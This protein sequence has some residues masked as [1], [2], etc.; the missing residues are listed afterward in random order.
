MCL[1]GKDMCTTIEAV[2]RRM[3]HDSNHVSIIHANH[4]DINFVIGTIFRPLCEAC[5]TDPTLRRA[6]GILHDWITELDVDEDVV[7][8]F[9]DLRSC[10][11]LLCASSHDSRIRVLLDTYFD[12][13]SSQCSYIQG[14]ASISTTVSRAYVF[15]TVARRFLAELTTTQR[16]RSIDHAIVADA[17]T[18]SVYGHTTPRTPVNL[19]RGVAYNV[20]DKVVCSVSV[21]AS[22]DIPVVST[23]QETDAIRRFGDKTL[24]ALTG[25]LGRHLICAGGAPCAAVCG[26]D[27]TDADLFMVGVDSIELGYDILRTAIRDLSRNLMNGSSIS[28][29]CRRIPAL[30]Y[31]YRNVLTV[32]IAT[33]SRLEPYTVTS[34]CFQFMLRLYRSESQVVLSFDLPPCRIFFDGTHFRATETAITSFQNRMCLPDPEMTTSVHRAMKYHKKGFSIYVPIKK[35]EGVVERAIGR[36]AMRFD[37]AHLRNLAYENRTVLTLVSLLAYSEMRQRYTHDTVE[38]THITESLCLD[39]DDGRTDMDARGPT[40]PLPYRMFPHK[41]DFVLLHLEDLAR[42]ELGHLAT[43]LQ[44]PASWLVL[45]P[46]VRMV[47]PDAAS[48]SFYDTDRLFSDV[49]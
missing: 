24:N 6:S 41:S 19:D 8:S 14:M 29:S 2:L 27:H 35:V 49:V 22:P 15:E 36:V 1:H 11:R 25:V 7:R 32:E 28:Q 13:L 40:P 9:R 16:H 3:F 33:R 39:D 21:W 43:A 46:C 45:D 38:T 17:A 34:F 37:L 5:D 47:R 20:F 18:V 23:Q 31:L 12:A 26:C 4:E 30:V 10:I 44:S 48:K 42:G